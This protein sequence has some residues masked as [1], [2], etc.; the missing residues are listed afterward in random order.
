[1]LYL[2][3]Y[4]PPK[5]NVFSVSVSLSDIAKSVPKAERMAKDDKNLP[6][7]QSDS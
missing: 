5:L 6:I 2:F 3:C 7:C 4:L 1:M